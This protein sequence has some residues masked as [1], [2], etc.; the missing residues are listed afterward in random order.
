MPQSFPAPKLVVFDMDGTL[1]DAFGDIAAAVNHALAQLGRRP[2]ALEQV[3]EK[4]GGGGRHLMRRCLGDGA[5]REEIEQA[6]DAWRGYYSEHPCD[7]ARLYPGAIETLKELKGL[8]IRTAILSNKLD[9]LT[10]DIAEQIG[11][12]AWLDVIQGE[13]LSKPKKPDPALLL[14]IMKRFGAEPA[15]TVMVGDGNLDMDVARNA[16]TRAIGVSWGVHRPETLRELGA[17][18]VLDQLDHLL[19]YLRPAS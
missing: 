13:D 17:E 14:E 4:V 10:R 2:L 5:T 15:E 11:L 7:L 3:T 19:S 6:F 16:K 9:S 8:G 1:V 12:A 18:T